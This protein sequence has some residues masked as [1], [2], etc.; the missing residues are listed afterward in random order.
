MQEEVQKS[1]SYPATMGKYEQQ[2]LVKERYRL[3]LKDSKTAPNSAFTYQ[4]WDNGR[5]LPGRGELTNWDCGDSLGYFQCPSCGTTDKWVKNCSKASCPICFENWLARRTEES[6]NRL[7]Q[8]SIM[9]GRSPKHVVLSPPPDANPTDTEINRMWRLLGAKGGLWIPH[10]WRF[11]DQATGNQISWK[12][13]DINPK[14]KKKIPAFGYRSFH[15]HGLVFG[16]LMQSDRFYE[17]SGGWVYKNKGERRVNQGRRKRHEKFSSA[18]AT[19]Y[20]LLSHTSIDGRKQTVHWF[21]NCSNNRMK[22]DIT[23]GYEARQCPVC[24]ID[25]L[26]FRVREGVTTEVDNLQKV[27]YKFYTFREVKKK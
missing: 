3:Y 23:E 26:K 19:L 6:G 13:T 10:P 1:H 7:E 24:K 17:L 22:V 2:K 20:Y 14:S 8:A 12:V 4:Y 18:K 16:F 21:G 25:M 9:L 11:G 27:R 5:T 15:V